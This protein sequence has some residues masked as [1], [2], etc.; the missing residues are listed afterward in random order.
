[1]RSF[2]EYWEYRQDVAVTAL[3]YAALQMSRCIIAELALKGFEQLAIPI[4]AAMEEENA[5][6]DDYPP[7]S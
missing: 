7:A 5:E 3:G 6:M 4:E 1:M 2:A